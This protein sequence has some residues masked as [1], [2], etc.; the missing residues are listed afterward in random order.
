MLRKALLDHQKNWNSYVD[1]AGYQFDD[2]VSPSGRPLREGFLSSQIAALQASR[3]PVQIWGSWFDAGTADSALRWFAAAPE[4]PIE[5]YL[6]AW[7]HGGGQRVDPLVPGTAE[8][9][10]GAP[11]PARVFLDFVQRALTAPTQFR[12][13]I[14]YYTAGAAIWRKTAS[15]PPAGLNATKFYFGPEDGLNALTAVS[16]NGSDNYTV[17]FTATTGKTNRWT[18]QLGGGMVDYGDRAGADRKLRTYSSQP[19]DRDIEITGAPLLDLHIAATHPDGA[20]FVY[21]EAVQP[22]G[23]VVYL[24][25]GELRLA[26]RGPNAAQDKL[27]GLS[28]SFARADAAFL[29]PGKPVEA[30]IV[31]HTISAMIPKGDRL[32]VAIAGA[33]ADTFARIPGEGAP[34]FTIYRSSALSSFIDIPMADWHQAPKSA[35]TTAAKLPDHAKRA[36]AADEIARYDNDGVVCLRGLFDL[37]WIEFLRD[38]VEVAM[39]APG[40]DAEEYTARA[41]SGRFFGDLDLWKRDPAFRHY[42]TRSPCAEIAGTIMR[43]EKINIFYDQLLVKEPQTRERTPWH[44]DQPYWAVE[45]RQVCSIW[46]PL[47]IVPRETCVEFVKGSHNWEA[48]CPH[49]FAG[50]HALP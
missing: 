28:P 4:A 13:S 38:A 22:D 33:D 25:E 7:T 32:R 49:H 31:L 8:S 44:Q 30:A 21:L 48:H 41:S 27:Q 40:T 47:D 35:M 24:T 29:E 18:T 9:E 39:A 34:I 12:R 14:S 19:L 36:V 17:D 37:G 46:L 6:G 15:W 20:V 1:T 50:R 45:G 42:V 10:P 5:V 3:V 2:D 16:A 23:K 26:L 11:V 43:S